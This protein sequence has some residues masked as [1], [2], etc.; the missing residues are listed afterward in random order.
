MSAQREGLFGDI[1]DKFKDFVT[2]DERKVEQ[3]KEDPPLTP[4][5]C[6]PVPPG[7]P[8]VGDPKLLAEGSVEHDANCP[9]HPDN[10]ASEEVAS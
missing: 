10:L 5:C 3:P 2:D 9:N 4:Q 6:G 8:V 1:V 7:W